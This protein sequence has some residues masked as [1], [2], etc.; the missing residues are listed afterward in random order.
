LGIRS[1]D[2]SVVR[3]SI[4]VI[5]RVIKRDFR[6]ARAGGVTITTVTG[7]KTTGVLLMGPAWVA[8]GRF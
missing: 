7:K 8:A 6:K 3:D 1:A 2:D 5:D 4:E